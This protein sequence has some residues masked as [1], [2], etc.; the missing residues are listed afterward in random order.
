MPVVIGALGTIPKG[1]DWKSWK[2][3]DVPRPSKVQ[4][5]KDRQ[6]C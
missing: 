2:S 5:Y 3:E 1:L 6:E 4:H